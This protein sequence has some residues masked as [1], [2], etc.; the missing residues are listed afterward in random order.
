MEP[1]RAWPEGSSEAQAECADSAARRQ[2]LSGPSPA[3]TRCLS[4]VH[5]TRC[6]GFE[7]MAG[8]T[9]AVTGPRESPRPAL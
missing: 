6:V 7:D 4:G 5:Q 9:P 2:P 3:H 1:A 8:V